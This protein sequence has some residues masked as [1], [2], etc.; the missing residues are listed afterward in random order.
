M[1]PRQ[2]LPFYGQPDARDDYRY[3]LHR[4]IG[5]G[6]GSVLSIM[7]NP[8]DALSLGSPDIPADNDQTVTRCINLA[9]SWDND[10]G[11]LTVVN[12]FAFRTENPADLLRHQNRIGEHNNEAIEWAL[13]RIY[14]H[15]GRVVCAW[16]NHGTHWCRN[17]YVLRKLEDLN[18]QGYCLH[19]TGEG[20]PKHPR[21][22]RRGTQAV[23]LNCPG[24][25][26]G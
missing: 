11:D 15:N 10:Y 16:G 9:R 4:D 3:W 19:L 6:E 21:V 24:N 26:G 23:P 2:N 7:L 18:I 14:Q 1:I 12:L 5:T 13:E 8:S 22:V 17:C 25:P 20:H